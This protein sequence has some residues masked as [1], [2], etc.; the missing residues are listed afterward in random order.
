MLQ[1]LLVE[2]HPPFEVVWVA[3]L[4]WGTPQIVIFFF[5][6]NNG[7]DSVYF[8]LLKQTCEDK[9]TRTGSLG[10]KMKKAKG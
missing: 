6:L 4:L 10:E 2:F 8:P 3:T 1:Q 9:T 5:L 7:D